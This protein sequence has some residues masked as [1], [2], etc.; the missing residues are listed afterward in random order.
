[1]K[2]KEITLTFVLEA[3]DE[4]F[5]PDAEQLA[6]GIVEGIPREWFDAETPGDEYMIWDIV[7]ADRSPVEDVTVFVSLMGGAFPGAIEG[8]IRVFNGRVAASLPET[9]NWVRFNDVPVQDVT[10]VNEYTDEGDTTT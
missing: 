1:M 9:T 8:D 7:S 5:F 4:S 2:R 10:A 6:S 3:D